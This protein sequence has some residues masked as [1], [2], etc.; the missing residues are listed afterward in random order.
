MADY[1][2]AATDVALHGVTLEEGVADTVTVATTADYVLMVHPG[3]TEPVYVGFSPIA[4]GD[5]D[6]H[7]VFGGFGLELASVPGG[8]TIHIVSDDAATYT[9][10]RTSAKAVRYAI[11]AAGGGGIIGTITPEDIGAAP[12]E[13]THEQADITGLTAALNGK[14]S[15]SHNHDADYAAI[16]H[17][18]DSDYAAAGHTHTAGEVSGLA[19]VATSGAYSDLSGTPSIP[20]GDQLMTGSA[21]ALADLEGAPAM[22]DFNA[23]LAILRTRGVLASE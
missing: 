4:V 18:H 5:A 9:L 20:S 11:A 2:L 7:A 12:E 6:A 22:E 23:L 1:S 16:D 8:T 13:H 3:A 19:A 10:E 14:A 21:T 17:D 15:T